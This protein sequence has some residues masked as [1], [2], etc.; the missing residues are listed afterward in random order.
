MC[1][2]IGV[3]IVVDGIMYVLVLMPW[4]RRVLACCVVFFVW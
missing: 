1:I 4:I 2:S 3:I